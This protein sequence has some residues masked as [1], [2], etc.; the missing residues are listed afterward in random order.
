M[1]STTINTKTDLKINVG[2]LPGML[3]LRK[4]ST[5]KLLRD[6]M[7]VEARIRWREKKNSGHGEKLSELLTGDREGLSQQ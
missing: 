7:D 6:D 2:F 4:F 5:G 1:V 3:H